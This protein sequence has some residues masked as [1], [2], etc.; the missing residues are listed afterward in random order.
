[1]VIIMILVSLE[2]ITVAA[3]VILVRGDVAAILVEISDVVAMIIVLEDEGVV[4]NAI[5]NVLKKTK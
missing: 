3:V 4:M 2:D 1:V 5:M